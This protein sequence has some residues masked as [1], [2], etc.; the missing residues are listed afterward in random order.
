MREKP[1]IGLMPRKIHEENVK[2]KR[3]NEVCGAITRYYNTGMEIDIE[4]IEEYNE[5]IKD[6]NRST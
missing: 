2:A 1:P 4:W 3:F 6:D 5:L